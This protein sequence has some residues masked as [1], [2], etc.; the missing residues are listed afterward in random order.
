MNS[1]KSLFDK[2]GSLD[3]EQNNPVS[4]GIDTASPL[5]IARIMN[6]EDAGVA[7][8]VSKKLNKVAEGITLITEAFKNGGR[9]IYAGSGTSG[10]IGVVDASEC[11][12]TFGTPFDMVKGLIAGGPEAMFR[13]QEG[14]E[15][16]PELGAKDI[17]SE[18]AGANDVVCGLA[19]SGRTPY[20]AGALSKAKE[21]GAKTIFICCV[22]ESQLDTNLHPDVLISVPVGPEVISGS[23]RLKSGTAQK[24]VC[25]M[26]T[27]GAM[28]QLG[29]VYQNVMVDLQLTNQKLH[30]R[31]RRIVMQLADVNYDEASEALDKAG[32]HV[33]SAL[34]MTIGKVDYDEAQ[35][36]LQ[37]HH[38]F[39]QKALTS[40]EKK[41]E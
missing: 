38:G 30:E 9:L 2:L 16:K 22:D 20:V 27:T 19:A 17:V 6:A 4:A 40:I 26:L 1:D 32:N 41:N 37:Q 34:V 28:I 29:K 18:K 14:A 3:T 12:P 7:V 35:L 21:L 24:M 11:P 5:D 36:I 31:A 13:A 15:D 33:K 23:T 25:N 8:A 39:V 10:R